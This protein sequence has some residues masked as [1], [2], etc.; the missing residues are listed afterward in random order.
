LI[1]KGFNGFFCICGDNT[2][3]FSRVNNLKVENWKRD[4]R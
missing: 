1:P 2:Q 3:A 4:I